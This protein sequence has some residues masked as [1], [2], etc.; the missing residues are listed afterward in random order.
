MKLAFRLLLFGLFTVCAHADCDPYD[1][2]NPTIT[3]PFYPADRQNPIQVDFHP[4]GTLPV[5]NW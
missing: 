1:P 3:N 2:A 5:I 4:H